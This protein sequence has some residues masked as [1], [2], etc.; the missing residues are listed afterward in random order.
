MYDVGFY[1]KEEEM[2]SI[3]KKALGLSCRKSSLTWNWRKV[4]PG[5]SRTSGCRN[6]EEESLAK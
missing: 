6:E 4:S 5:D 3:W 1:L 2:R